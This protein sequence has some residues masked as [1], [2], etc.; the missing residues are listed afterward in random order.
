MHSLDRA[1]KSRDRRMTTLGLLREMSGD[2]LENATEMIWHDWGFARYIIKRVGPETI[3]ED[4]Q[5]LYTNGYETEEDAFWDAITFETL[6][7]L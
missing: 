4:T 2:R 6:R 1:L 5:Q 3:A 7:M